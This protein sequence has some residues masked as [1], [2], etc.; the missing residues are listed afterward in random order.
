[1]D[2][3]NARAFDPGVLGISADE[4]SMEFELG[5]IPMYYSGSWTA[6]QCESPENLIQGKIKVFP[7]PA[8]PGGKGGIS[9]FLGGAID[10]Y[11]VNS[12]TKYPDEAVAFAI[13]LT[14]YQSNEGYIVGDSVTAWKS[15]ID[16]S[17]VNPVLIEINKLTDNADGYVLAWDTFLTGSAIDAHYNL[18]QQLVGGAV[19]PEEFARKMEEANV[20]AIA[21]T[22]S[23]GN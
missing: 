19:S 10:T 1:V 12:K 3:V 17:K 6:A 8:V 16:E 20:A 18:L 5:N 13:A 9:K 22:G 21:E 23:I 14:E 4:A 15:D 2:L 7:L 11:M